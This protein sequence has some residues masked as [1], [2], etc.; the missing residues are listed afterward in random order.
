MSGIGGANPLNRGS[1]RGG[2]LPSSHTTSD[3]GFIFTEVI[4]KK[5]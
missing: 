1:V 3:R 2:F 4:P 5:H